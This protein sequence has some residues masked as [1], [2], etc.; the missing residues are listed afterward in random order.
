MTAPEPTRVLFVC[1]ANQRRSPTAERLGRDS[2]LNC[3]SRGVA[4]NPDMNRVDGV[5][6]M[7]AFDQDYEWATE[8]VTMEPSLKTFIPVAHWDKIHCL[9]IADRYEFDSPTLRA[10]LQRCIDIRKSEGRWQ[11]CGQCLTGAWE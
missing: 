11:D 1:L 2:G 7:Q 3:R 10:I 8:I 6:P 5:T 9:G 4:C